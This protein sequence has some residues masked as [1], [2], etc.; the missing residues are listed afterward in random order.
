MYHYIDIY[1][2][3]HIHIIDIIHYVQK[4]IYIY[5]VSQMLYVYLCMEY[6]PTWL[7]DF[8]GECWSI[9]QH[10]GASGYTNIGDISHK[11]TNS[12]W[13]AMRGLWMPWPRNWPKGLGTGAKARARRW[14][15][16]CPQFFSMGTGPVGWDF[17]GF[18]REMSGFGQRNSHNDPYG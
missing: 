1:I 10:H 18:L 3:I 17:K 16:S 9:F 11:M 7:G 8:W 14:T 12:L 15:L 4:N 6:L 5:D 13:G 2:I